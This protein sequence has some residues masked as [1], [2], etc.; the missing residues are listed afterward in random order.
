MTKD[1]A[2]INVKQLKEQ[3]LCKTTGRQPTSEHLLWR[4][5]NV[6]HSG[7]QKQHILLKKQTL[8][9]YSLS[10]NSGSKMRTWQHTYFLLFITVTPS[11]DKLCSSLYVII[12]F[13]TVS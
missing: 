3:T 12:Y 10:L 7:E 11:G 1:M 8:N 9:C 4:D 6:T 13:Y 2:K 5:S